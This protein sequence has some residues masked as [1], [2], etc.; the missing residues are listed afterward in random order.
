MKVYFL[1]GKM[2]NDPPDNGCQWMDRTLTSGIFCV[3]ISS[4]RELFAE[5]RIVATDVVKS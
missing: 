3:G 4:Y 5:T 2:I 1:R